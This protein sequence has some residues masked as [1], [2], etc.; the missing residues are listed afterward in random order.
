MDVPWASTST[1]STPKQGSVA[2]PGL[3]DVAPGRGAIM[4]P[5]W[6]IWFRIDSR[7]FITESGNGN[8]GVINDINII[9]LLISLSR[10]H[11]KSCTILIDLLNQSPILHDELRYSPSQSASKCQLQLLVPLRPPCVAISRRMDWSAPR[12][13]RLPTWRRD[14]WLRDNNLWKSLE[15]FT[16][17]WVELPMNKW[18]WASIMMYYLQWAPIMFGHVV[19]SCGLQCSH[20]SRRCVQL[21]YLNDSLIDLPSGQI[22]PAM[23]H[24]FPVFLMDWT[25]RKTRKVVMLPCTSPQSATCAMHQ[26]GMEFPRRARMSV[27]SWGGRTVS[28]SG[29]RRNC[30][31]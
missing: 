7:L 22:Y 18:V 19:I 16:Y 13:C 21:G 15:L 31:Y 20:G 14:W 17:S 4:C 8:A 9:T 6:E 5:P 26:G 23:L 1:G 29:L 12:R 28:R 25:S 10:L 3:S 27:H 30:L 24:I 11:Q 2:E